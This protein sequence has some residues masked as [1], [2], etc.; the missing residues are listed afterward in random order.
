MD[1]RTRYWLCYS[2]NGHTLW[3]DFRL[4]C[5]L[6]AS[7]IICWGVCMLGGVH[8]WGCA[9]RG[10]VH[11]AHPPV[12]RRTPVKHNLLKLRLRAVK[13]HCFKHIAT[14]TGQKW[15]SILYNQIQCQ[16]LPGKYSTVAW[17]LRKSVWCT[18]TMCRVYFVKRLYCVNWYNSY[19]QLSNVT[20]SYLRLCIY[21]SN[22]EE[23][24]KKLKW[25]CWN[26][27]GGQISHKRCRF[28]KSNK[29]RSDLIWLKT[30]FR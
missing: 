14:V 19:L 29:A 11:A 10:G 20:I 8:A 23:L 4:I 21:C 7:R 27:S 2:V 3:T 15:S 5:S 25:W 26:F 28:K 1:E 24:G 22:Y 12:D 18:W 9:C 30:A 13:T 17:S 6:S 16:Q